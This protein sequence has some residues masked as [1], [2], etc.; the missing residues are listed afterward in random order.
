MTESVLLVTT[1]PYSAA[2]RLAGAFASLGC[3]VEAV[4]PHGHPLGCSRY[5]AATHRYSALAPQSALEAAI[6]AADPDRVVACDDRALA[7]LLTLTRFEPLLRRSFGA[8]ENYP[9]LC[10][11]APSMAAARAEGIA[12]PLTLAV[13]DLDDLAAALAAVGLPCVMKTDSSW[14]GEGVRFVKTV[15]EAQAGFVRMRGPPSRLRSLV[16]AARRKDLHFL[17]QARHPTPAVV[18]LQ[19]WV[20]GS[21][22]TT[23]FA[24]REGKVTAIQH[25]DVVYWQGATGPASVMQCAAD[26]VMDAAAAKI[27]AR[28]GLSGLHGLDFMRD[29]AGQ[30]HLIEVNPRA[31]QICHLPLDGDVAAA[32]VGAPARPAT[33]DLRQ[34]ALFPHLLVLGD[35]PAAVYPDIPWDD[36]AVVRQAGGDALLPP[37]KA[38]ETPFGFGK[39]SLR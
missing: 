32:L 12:A 31:T 28:F 2:A 22:A 39:T 8:L 26:P 5:V 1:V 35:L 27:A 37:A 24:A 23:V 9:V 4:F 7:L 18:N 10:A 17:A 21:P 11:R 15:E 20:E 16:R 33:T 29:G 38:A 25:M 36:P 3:R 34:I 30:P 6:R 19:A 13:H 14:G